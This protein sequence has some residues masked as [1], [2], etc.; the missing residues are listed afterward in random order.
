MNHIELN[1]NSMTE[2]SFLLLQ[3]NTNGS[4]EHPP[5]RAGKVVIIYA[6]NYLGS[7]SALQKQERTASALGMLMVMLLQ[8]VACLNYFATLG[9]TASVLRQLL[10]HPPSVWTL[11]QGRALWCEKRSNY[12]SFL[13]IDSTVVMKH[14]RYWI[15]FIWNAEYFYLE[16]QC[17]LYRYFARGSECFHSFLFLRNYNRTDNCRNSRNQFDLS[18]RIAVILHNK[19]SQLSQARDCIWRTMFNQE[20][21]SHIGSEKC[22]TK[23]ERP[24]KFLDKH[25]VHNCRSNKLPT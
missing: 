19:G 9:D 22:K 23:W 17:P 5:W 14:C 4:I 11:D 21:I 18:T 2:I 24:S 12:D 15:Y 10:T 8:M 13:L 1:W 7:A 20:W 3:G 16:H 6:Y 25:E